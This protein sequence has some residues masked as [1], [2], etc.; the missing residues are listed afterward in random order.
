MTRDSG[1]LVKNFKEMMN[2]DK[3]AK[4]NPLKY[5]ELFT[6]DREI[7]NYKIRQRLKDGDIVLCDRYYH[8][9]IAYQVSQGV[10]LQT[11]LEANKKFLIP[12][13]T[14]VIDIPTEEAFGRMEKRG[15]K[16]DKFEDYEFQKQVREQYLK[17]PE[18]GKILDKMRG[19]LI[20]ENIVIINGN[21]KKEKVFQNIKSELIKTLNIY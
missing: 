8:A 18:Y 1:S 17:M 13:L 4:S 20:K 9:T 16:L 14:L 21:Q 6:N 11:I 2:K 7:H 3:D 10:D 15:K 5:L 19:N 12:A